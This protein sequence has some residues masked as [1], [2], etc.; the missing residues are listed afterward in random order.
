[1]IQKLAATL[2][3]ALQAITPPTAEVKLRARLGLTTSRAPFH[4]SR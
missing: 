2:A 4:G 1:M 3:D